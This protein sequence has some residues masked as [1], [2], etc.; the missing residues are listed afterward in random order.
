MDLLAQA[1]P[2]HQRPS[3][4]SK[5]QRRE[6]RTGKPKN[7]KEQLL[8]LTA[9]EFGIARGPAFGFV[10]GWGLGFGIPWGRRRV[11]VFREFRRARPGA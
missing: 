10:C 2:R 8:A 5:Q 9:R 3:A 11:R 1:Q 6:G 4:V 7:A